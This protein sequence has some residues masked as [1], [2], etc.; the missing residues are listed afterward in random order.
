MFA[1]F[2]PTAASLS[3]AELLADVPIDGR[4]IVPT[5]LG[6]EQPELAEGGDALEP[7]EPLLLVDLAQDVGEQ[8]STMLPHRIQKS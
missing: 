8:H 7:D 2:L 4:C 5:L 6:K 1:D 3:Q